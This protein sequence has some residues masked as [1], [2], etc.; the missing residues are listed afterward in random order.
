MMKKEGF[1]YNDEMEFA[2]QFGVV[3]NTSRFSI[4]NGRQGNRIGNTKMKI[5]P[6]VSPLVFTKF[7]LENAAFISLSDI[8]EGLPGYREIPVSIEMD[9]ELR[10]AYT[11][12]E[13]DLRRSVGFNSVGGFKALGSLVQALSVFPDQCYDQPPVV[14]PDT[15]EVIVRPPQ[16]AKGPRRKEE[17]FIELVKEKVEAGEKVLVYYHWTN[18]TD[19]GERLPALL[20]EEGIKAAVL[21]SSTTSSK[22]R[23]QWIKKKVEKDGIDVL[24]CNPTLVETGLD[25]LDFTTIIFYQLGYN[26]FTM[27]Q[28]SRRSWRLSQT[29]D[30]EVYFLY[31]ENT[32]QEQ[33]LSLMA[34][35]LQSA[36]AIE[37]KFSEEGLHAM[38][39]NEDLLTQIANSVV[40]GIKHTV[41]VNVFGTNKKEEEENILDI[42]LDEDDMIETSS[43]EDEIEVTEMVIE[44]PASKFT[45]YT[46]Y[47]PGKKKTRRKPKV[48][49]THRFMKELFDKKQ[50]V[51]NLF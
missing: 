13:N 27:R 35:K 26:I 2:R 48:T 15:G 6:G 4:Q 46:V 36:Q 50:H 44:K 37:G 10:E 12:L 18:R 47:K 9:N 23:E 3:R 19:L 17:R 29:K 49:N 21:T 25:L 38:S 42:M 39:N 31:Y 1:D 30:I 11:T 32:I 40:Q 7:L 14:H 5:L 8:S 22:N 45:M 43:A 34:T 33:A 51:A 41:D 16:L 20:K 28:A 24:I